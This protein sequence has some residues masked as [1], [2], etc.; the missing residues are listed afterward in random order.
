MLI[1]SDLRLEP[2]PPAPLCEQLETRWLLATLQDGVLTQIGTN[3]NDTIDVQK[4]PADQNHGDY[5]TV[6][7]NGGALQNFDYWSVYYINIQ[8]AGGND[9][10]TVRDDVEQNATVIGGTG[11]DTMAGGSGMDYLEGNDGADLIGGGPAYDD[12]YGNDGNDILNGGDGDDCLR[13]GAGDDNLVGGDGNDWLDG[14]DDSDSLFGEG[15]NDWYIDGGA[16]DDFLEGGS[17]SDGLYGG[18]GD[19]YF[20]LLGGDLDGSTDTMDGGDGNDTAGTYDHAL[21]QLTN[22]ENGTD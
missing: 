7:V 4:T 22:I 21:D 8:A 17:G 1:E 2:A 9:V 20:S 11:N 19:D 16:G 14:G 3:G 12:I 13:G 10:V 6:Q 18:T 5:L 15:G